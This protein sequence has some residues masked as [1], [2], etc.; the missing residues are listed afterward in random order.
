MTDAD[1]PRGIRLVELDSTAPPPR[2]THTAPPFA[3][4]TVAH[5]VRCPSSPAKVRPGKRPLSISSAIAW[6]TTST[7]STQK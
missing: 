4:M 7:H 5:G 2:A 3:P 1:G 6:G